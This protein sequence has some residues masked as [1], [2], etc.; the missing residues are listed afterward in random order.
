MAHLD[1]IHEGGGFRKV[2]SRARGAPLPRVG[3]CPTGAGV[4]AM[5]RSRTPAATTTITG[6]AKIPSYVL[7]LL[8]DSI[9]LELLMS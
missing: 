1:Y 2:L 6:L 5:C 3:V 4:A 7:L 8:K 9:Y